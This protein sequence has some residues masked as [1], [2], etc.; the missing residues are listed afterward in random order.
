MARGGRRGIRAWV[1][2]ATLA[3]IIGA[4]ATPA[5]ALLRYG[6]LQ[7]SGSV[8]SQTLLRSSE[9]YEWQFVQNR[10]TALLR[11]DYAWGEEVQR[12][13]LHLSVGV[14]F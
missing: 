12:G 14:T 13:R 2:C 3:A 7:L 8:D 11:V 10:N 4:P 9:I 5:A 6:P 1:L